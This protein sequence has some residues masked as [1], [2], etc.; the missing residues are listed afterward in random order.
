[1]LKKNVGRSR[2]EEKIIFPQNEEVAFDQKHVNITVGSLDLPEHCHAS[3]T[4]FNITFNFWLELTE[5]P[6]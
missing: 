3:D 4:S 1:M 2:K 5:N 6:W